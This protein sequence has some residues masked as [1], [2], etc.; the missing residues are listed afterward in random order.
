MS[1]YLP[2]GLSIPVPEADG[3]SAPFWNGLK[4]GKVL[5]QRCAAC[6]EWQWGPEWICHDCHSMTLDWVEV[7]PEGRIFSWQ[8][9]WHPVSPVLAGAVPYLVVLV[10]LPEAGNIRMLGNLL[11]DPTQDVQIGAPVKGVFEHRTSADHSFTLLQWE[12]AS[13]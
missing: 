9:S 7:M 3:L 2:D 6:G 11:G 13:A 8:R 1:G 12:V 10:E 4:D 5:V